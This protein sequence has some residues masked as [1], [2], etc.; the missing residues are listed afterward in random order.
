[1]MDKKL[2]IDGGIAIRNKPLP[3][4]WCG[5]HHIDGREAEAVLGVIESHS[6]FRYYGPNLRREVEKLEE[7]FAA[8]NG[9]THAL[10]VSSGTAALQVA[11]GALGVGPGDEVIVPG[12]FWVATVGAVVRSGAV[13]VLADVDDSFSLDPDKL[14]E[15]IS[16]RTKAVIPVHMGGVIGRIGE[17]V[18][19]AH[20]A[21][22]KVLEDCAQA[23]GASQHGIK[24]GA[25]GDIA[26]YSFQLNKN[27][28]SGEGG[29]V[30]TNDASLYRRAFAIHD[31]GYPR[32]N[33]RLVFNDESTQLW[34]IGA[35][36]GELPAAVARVQLAKLDGICGNMRSAKNRI[37]YGISDIKG[38]TVRRVIDP[39]GDSG[40]FLKLTFENRDVSLYF[41]TALKAEGIVGA[42]GAFYPIHMDDWGLHIYYN[43]PSLVNKRGI[44]QVSPWDLTE[45]SASAGVSYGKGT[46]PRLDD[47][48][49]RTIIICVASNLA[50]D[51]VNDII[52]AI[53]KVAAHLL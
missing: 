45:N 29:M 40:A 4:E 41:V 47:L 48:V 44:S 10:A 21:G 26:I 5:T 7:E 9:V 17:I 50:D 6:L 8:Y 2:A 11:L 49:S 23:C 24:A 37:K 25:F 3:Q 31:L 15:K 53:R 51:D 34:G 32:V 22:V 16:A 19:V 33:G 30:V 20:A 27:M 35:R 28:T 43:I 38:I 39:A 13:P 12:Y 42:P 18:K 52:A 36:M 1:M 46:C 14:K